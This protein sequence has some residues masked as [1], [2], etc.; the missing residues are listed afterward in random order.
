MLVFAAD[1]QM[2]AGGDTQETT[3]A[4]ANAF[5]IQ[6]Q[7]CRP[8]VTVWLADEGLLDQVQPLA[9]AVHGDAI[10]TGFERDLCA[11][12]MQGDGLFQVGLG[13]LCRVAKYRF[14]AVEKTLVR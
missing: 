6:Q 2:I 5:R 4:V 7:E 11:S 3:D 12:C 10:G 9:A 8:R 13:T 14:E 1:D